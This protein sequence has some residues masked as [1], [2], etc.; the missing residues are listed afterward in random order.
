MPGRTPPSY[1]SSCHHS[2]F[3]A[4]SFRTN[5]D[6]YTFSKVFLG[7]SEP[8]KSSS[9][10]PQTQWKLCLLHD[11]PSYQLRLSPIIYPIALNK[12]V[13]KSVWAVMLPVTNAVEANNMTQLH[14]I[15]ATSGSSLS[16]ATPFPFPPSP[17]WEPDDIGTLVFGC[18]ASILGVLTLW[19]TFWLRRRRVL[20]AGGDGVY[21]Y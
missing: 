16:T 2:A 8:T 7:H 21:M 4:T 18:I 3:A 1:G 12:E 14:G 6:I 5:L 20:H 11:Y 9:P 17:Q 10:S 13:S 15:A 19:A